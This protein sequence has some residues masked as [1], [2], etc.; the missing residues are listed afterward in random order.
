MISLGMLTL[1]EKLTQELYFCNNLGQD[2][3]C[4]LHFCLLYGYQG[5]YGYKDP[6]LTFTREGHK[7]YLGG[8]LQLE[9]WNNGIMGS[10]IIR[11]SVTL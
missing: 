10:G 5:S 6:I 9:C 8:W 1:V 3:F 2:F 7:T 11:R 4:K